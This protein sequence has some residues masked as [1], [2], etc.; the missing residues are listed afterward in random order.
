MLEPMTIPMNDEYY[1]DGIEDENENERKGKNQAKNLALRGCLPL[2]S[3]PTSQLL[4]GFSGSRYSNRKADFDFRAG[5]V[6]Y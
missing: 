2:R 1:E 6:K 3:P 5:I 4:R